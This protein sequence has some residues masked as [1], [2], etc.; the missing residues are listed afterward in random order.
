MRPP[1]QPSRPAAPTGTTGGR[2]G[3]RA[4]QAAAATAGAGLACVAWGHFVERHLY[5]LRRV[6]V[7]VLPVGSLPL[8]VLHVSDL[9]LVPGQ[10]RRMRWVHDLAALEPDLVVNT[11]DNMSSTRAVPWVLRTFA[12]LLD[13]PGVFVL[14]S[15]DYY[16]PRRKNPLGYVIEGR[17]RLSGD[18]THRDMPW[19]ELVA[20]FTERGWVDLTHRRVRLEV[21][22]VR[23]EFVGVDDPHLD[24]DEYEGV[25]GPAAAD[26][27]LTIG[28][29]HA[30]YQRVLD[31]M[32]ADGTGL[33]IAGHTHGGQVCL[34]GWGALTTN[35][36][37]DA[38]RV[39]GLSRWWPGAGS[40]P[41]SEAPDDAAWLEVSAGLGHSP[42]A[43]Y[44]F[45]CR[46]EATLLTL[47]PRESSAPGT[48]A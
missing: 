17:S 16:S 31:A 46:P 7:P 39:K 18:R 42:M 43:P 21:E 44:R 5:T 47:V 25:A 3:R 4:A 13:V 2:F 35:C 1:L 12:D 26:A 29:T 24:L 9:H 33:V 14:G 28:V 6:T 8:R 41:S 20:A 37:L 11:G 30:P 19:E 15:N 34:P 45:A 40:R 32:V 22:G 23:L 36:D 48:G 10:E 27:D 38:G